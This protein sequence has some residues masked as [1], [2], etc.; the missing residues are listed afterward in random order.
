VPLIQQ[1]LCAVVIGWLPGATLF[2]IP[3]GD[4]DRRFALPAE[5][6]VFWQVIVSVALALSMVLV[7]AWF[8]RYQFRLLVMAQIGVAALPL[9]IWRGGLRVRGA[10]RIGPGAVLPCILIAVAT[11]VFF[12]PSEYVIAGKDPGTYVGE[13]V[14]IAQRGTLT[15]RDEVIASVP[16]PFRDL[17][18]PSHGRGEYYAIRFMGFF[19][20]DPGQGTVVG[21]FPHLFPA[22]LAI[23]YGFDGLTGVRRTTPVVAMLGVLAVYF[24]G[25]LM[26]GRLAAFA[27]CVLLLFNVV[28]VWFGRY[29]N[30]EVVMQGFVFS[31]ML[32]ILHRQRDEDN[33]FAVVGG[34]LLGLLL[35][36][37]LDAVFALGSVIGALTLQTLAGR[38]F[39]WQVPAAVV[40][41][42]LLAAAYMLGP[43]AA[44]AERYISFI[45]NMTLWEH[46]V[47]AG[48]AIAM[49]VGLRLSARAPWLRDAVVRWMPMLIA[50]VCCSAALY[51]L[52]LRHPEGRLA[53]HDAY[54]LRMY[55]AFYVTVP[56]VL[57]AILGFALFVRGWFWRGPV[58]YIVA[59]V[60]TFFLFYKIRI[61][62]EHFWAAR[63]MLPVIL[64]TTM[65]LVAAVAV[66]GR[67]VGPW[68]LRGARTALGLAFLALL[69]SHYFR[70]SSPVRAHIE[71]EGLI[72]RLEQLAAQFGDDDLVLVES[73][74]AGSD[75]HVFGMP[76]AYI[77]ARNVL[78]LNSAQPDKTR[79]AEF[80]TWAGTRYR[81]LF[82]VGAGGTNL[83]SFSYGLQPLYSDRFQVPE[84]ES[85][86]N[87]YPR[88]P[89]QKEFEYGVY[90]FGPAP[91]RSREPF[92]L[93]V[94][95]DDNLHVLRFHASET[96]DG[97]TFRWTG[98]Q[99][100]MSITSIPPGSRELVLIAGDGGRPA[101]APAATVDV[102]LDG[103][104]LGSTVVNGSF[105]PYSFVIPPALAARAAAA[106]EPVEL[107][108]VTTTWNP[109]QVLGAGDDRQLG[110]MLDRVTVK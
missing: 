91:P 98:G 34:L 66:G 79:L 63:R 18:F 109:A 83:L 110:I 87:A 67:A 35:F 23:G 41:V 74:D 44:Y 25:V 58:F 81:R 52:Y 15:T 82:F 40:P 45:K 54:A 69:G 38:R 12:P 61:V 30:A 24:T 88:G 106:A 46:G 37:R 59:A 57:A 72:P 5:E 19:I 8:E 84:Y 29:P 97:R 22:A 32:A 94:G 56:A 95:G 85:V 65:L 60:F 86:T 108:L 9:L 64:P 33:W 92:D 42:A 11:Q 76:L 93:D 48:V 107:R 104:R 103:E 71:Y 77:Y 21:Q 96:S 26:F 36:L 28:Q 31:A 78:V 55:A 68:W 100:V 53:I 70:A 39:P 47:I 62:P 50:F 16:E 6:R 43:M 10:R 13:G 17:F 99:S 1:L 105:A 75:T 89:R 90:A 14:Q 102:F 2:R 49:L 73:R 80:L 20:Q 101:A 3:L 27:A 7:L 51:A 4:R